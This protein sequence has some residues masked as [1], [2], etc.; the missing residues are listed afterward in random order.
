[1]TQ[2]IW[3]KNFFSAKIRGNVEFSLIVLSLKECAC[4]ISS[5][6]HAFLSDIFE[7]NDNLD[8]GRWWLF[9]KDTLMSLYT[10]I[11]H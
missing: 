4:N 6:S 2:K 5:I 1:M 8:V 3:G 9:C 7:E 11:K 10:I